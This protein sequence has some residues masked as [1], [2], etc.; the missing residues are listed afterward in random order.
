MTDVGPTNLPDLKTLSHPLIA[1]GVGQTHLPTTLPRLDIVESLIMRKM[2][3]HCKGR[4]FLDKE[5]N[6]YFYWRCTVTEKGKKGE[7]FQSLSSKWSCFVHCLLAG[8]VMSLRPKGHM[9]AVVLCNCDVLQ[10][11]LSVSW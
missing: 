2:T 7:A 1:A 10:Q 8:Q 9:F 3:L 5:S 6:E 11:G 4:Q